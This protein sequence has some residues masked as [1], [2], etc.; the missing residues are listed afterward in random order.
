[1]LLCSEPSVAR[2]RFAATEVRDLLLDLAGVPVGVR[3]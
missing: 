1:V 3:T 2:D